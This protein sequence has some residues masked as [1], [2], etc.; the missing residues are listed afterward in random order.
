MKQRVMCNWH[1]EPRSWIPGLWICTGAMQTIC[2]TD[3]NS[4]WLHA[5]NPYE[6]E[7]ETETESGIWSLKPGEWVSKP[8]IIHEPRRRDMRRSKNVY[9]TPKAPICRADFAAAAGGSPFSDRW[10]L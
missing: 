8:I 2:P 5:L 3:S 4:Y 10:A 6:P 9:G 1:E 7:P